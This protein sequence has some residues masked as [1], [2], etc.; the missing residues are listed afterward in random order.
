MSMRAPIT[1]VAVLILLASLT[2]CS[3]TGPSPSANPSV[4]E[5]AMSELRQTSGVSEANLEVVESRH[6]VA[7][8]VLLNGDVSPEDL[9]KIGALVVRFT[10]LADDG[11]YESAAPQLTLEKSNYSYF[12]GVSDDQLTS[13]LNYWL[14]LVRTGAEAVSVRSY[15]PTAV[16]AYSGVS[17]T[18]TADPSRYVL[19]DL[20]NGLNREDRGELIG[21]L[22]NVPDPGAAAGQWDVLDLATSTK[23]EY[24]GPNFPERD[25]MR[26]D[27]DT[28]DL[29]A[30]VPGLASIEVR[31]DDSATTPLLVQIVVFDD[32]MDSLETAKAEDAFAK[33]DA[34]GQLH[35]LL[36]LLESRTA[37]PYGVDLLSSPLTDG[38]NFHLW[39][40][41]HGCEF[42]SDTQ[43]PRLSNELGATW[44]SV[45]N[46]DRRGG[47]TNSEHCTVNGEHPPRP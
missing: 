44:I 26:A 39:F 6:Y 38:G 8:D 1:V 42:N 32:A 43:W 3:P 34:Y 47:A 9:E 46:P 25:R 36:R 31:R 35:E 17:A 12:A 37:D 41:V 30:Q 33:T 2:A 13:Q 18:T 28:A 15:Q 21:A 14:A 7:L 11:G 24:V 22:A 29:F 23:A 19:L 40:D 27:A 5:I 16:A 4:F 10:S 45:L 20:P